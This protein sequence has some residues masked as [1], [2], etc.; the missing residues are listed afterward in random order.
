MRGLVSS[1]SRSAVLCRLACMR[2]VPHQEDRTLRRAEVQV[3]LPLRLPPM[4]KSPVISLFC[5]LLRFRKPPSFRDGAKGGIHAGEL[6]PTINRNAP[7]KSLA[8]ILKLQSSESEIKQIRFE[9]YEKSAD[10]KGTGRQKG[11]MC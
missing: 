4:A 5:V 1:G 6:T 7:S 10:C 2:S 11:L 8:R 9:G 3:P